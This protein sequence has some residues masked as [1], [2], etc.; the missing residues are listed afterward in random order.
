MIISNDKGEKIFVYIRTNKNNRVSGFETEVFAE[1]FENAVA[2]TAPLIITFLNSS[3]VLKY[4][5]PFYIKR[6]VAWN[7]IG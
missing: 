7:D 4:K 5:T 2:I 6:I 3:F 1:S